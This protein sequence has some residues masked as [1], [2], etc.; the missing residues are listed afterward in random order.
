MGVI[1]IP[2][3]ILSILSNQSF[4][5]GVTTREYFLLTTNA[6][7][8]AS[9]P[10]SAVG[11]ESRVVCAEKGT[12][13]GP[14]QCSGFEWGLVPTNSGSGRMLFQCKLRQYI[15]ETMLRYYILRQVAVAKL[16][17]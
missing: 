9:S 10:L 13:L 6:T 7:V 15:T 17:F 8:N 3:L 11:V 12:I 1:F 4:G 16:S 14:A 5:S 2:V